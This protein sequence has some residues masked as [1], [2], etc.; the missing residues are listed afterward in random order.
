M[1]APKPTGSLKE[2]SVSKEQVTMP[3]PLP[4]VFTE[5]KG[6]ITLTD[7]KLWFMLLHLSWDELETHSK[8]GIWHEIKESELLSLFRK[9]T[10]TKDLD[11]LWGSGCRL[12]DIRARYERVD[13]KDERWKG[14]T[15][16][17]VCE[18]KKKSE[19]DG[20]FRY[21]FPAPLVDILLD[22]R[23]YARLHIPFIL[24]LKSKYSISL[25]QIL[26]AVANRRN[27]TLE[28]AL[29][30]LRRWLNVPE[31]KLLRWNNFYSK[32]LNPALKEINDKSLMSGI[33]AQAE[34]IRNG[35][36]GKVTRV[37]FIVEKTPKRLIF[38]EKLGV[39]PCQNK[40]NFL[41]VET[42]RVYSSYSSVDNSRVEIALYFYKKRFGRNCKEKDLTAK[43][44]EQA[45]NILDDLK[46]I[47]RVK[48]F[49]DIACTI[50][51]PP[52]FLVGLKFLKARIFPQLREEKITRQHENEI[53]KKDQERRDQEQQLR[54]E[55]MEYYDTLTEED[56]ESILAM[57]EMNT[58][59][60]DIIY[61][62]T[63]AGESV[64]MNKLFEFWQ[65]NR[66][67][68]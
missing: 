10:G 45:Q 8:V 28:V 66:R 5:L 51:N 46:S 14:A 17:F 33:V 55:F 61:K 35:R 19:R 22:P 47:E 57:I 13:E 64:R 65:D 44:L 11:R 63:R 7:S 42:S 15:G 24:Q 21:M 20:V 54:Q 26:E 49:I 60:K 37:L 2:E 12:S 27:P 53:E 67:L 68:S 16:M 40:K 58:F 6:N 43:D 9:Y 18:Y 25:Y 56:I 32:A 48:R 23:V 41:P 62:K 4:I 50:E 30:E 3:L 29:D 52:D 39:K 38:E 36:G 34:S 31:G 1:I 59:E